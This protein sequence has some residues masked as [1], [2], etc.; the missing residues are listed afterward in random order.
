M[1][2][3]NELKR[4]L[5]QVAPPPPTSHMPKVRQERK[6]SIKDVQ[7]MAEEATPQAFQALFEI[8]MDT[9]VDEKTRISALKEL[10]DR[11]MGK[12]TQRIEH[13]FSAADVVKRLQ[14][15]RGP[16]IDLEPEEPHGES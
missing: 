11:G 12:A 10:L 13:E 9:E 5:G 14:Q 4:L 15:A 3:E 8:G 1:A 7:V 16:V 6:L 2:D